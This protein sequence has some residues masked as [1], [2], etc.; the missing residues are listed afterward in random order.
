[1][2]NRMEMLRI[3]A[4]AAETSNFR[5]A[6]GR[7][8]ISP[9]SVTRAIKELEALFGEPLFHRSTR[10]VQISAFGEQLASQARQT[11]NS[12]DQLFQRHAQP[13]A[14]ELTGRVRIT[15]P[16]AVGRRF[17]LPLLGELMAEYPQ[18]EFDLRL[19]DLMTDAVDAQIDMGVRIGFIR[20][21]SYIARALAR[22][23]LFTV[24]TPALLAKT[25]SPSS[26][27]DLHNLPTSALVDRGSGRPWPWYF[28]NGRH[29]QPA[30]PSFTTD[31]QETELDAVLAGLAI[32][33][34]PSYL[35]LPA[36]RS[37]KLCTVL[38][39]QRPPPWDLFLY[40]PQRGPMPARIR[41]VYDRLA[42]CLGDPARVP[43]GVE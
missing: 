41:L 32:G 35:V 2:L 9:Q 18:I 17:V 21:R 6:A 16:H 40:R 24:A 42:E 39:E 10:Q 1:V 26:I 22:I 4:V 11:L 43:S 30:N 36:I 3:F 29:L 38:D 19:S 5:E 27:E 31:D 20:D 15:A 13:H 34:L 7:L 28:D 23:P 8:G 25:G 37:G 12:F 33:Q 14:T